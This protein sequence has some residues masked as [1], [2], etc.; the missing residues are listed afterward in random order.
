[1]KVGERA[2]G[3]PS[4]ATLKWQEDWFGIISKEVAILNPNVVIFFTGSDYDKFILQAFPDAKFGCLPGSE[5][6]EKELAA[7]SHNGLP[8]IAIRTYH[9]DFLSRKKATESY[10]NEIISAIELGL[11]G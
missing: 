10:L 3:C 9:P 1:V 6:S 7:L 5:R 11:I 2:G 4:P 8:K